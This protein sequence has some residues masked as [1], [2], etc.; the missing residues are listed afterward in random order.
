MVITR[1]WSCATSTGRALTL[2]TMAYLEVEEQERCAH[3]DHEEEIPAS[4]PRSRDS[5]LEELLVDVDVRRLEDEAPAGLGHDPGAVEH[6]IQSIIQHSHHDN[7]TDRWQ[8]L[9]S[10]GARRL[11]PSTSSQ[12]LRRLS[13]KAATIE[14]M[15]YPFQTSTTVDHR[16]RLRPPEVDSRSRRAQPEQVAQN[17]RWLVHERRPVRSQRH[18]HHRE[19]QDHLH[20]PLRTNSDRASPRSPRRVLSRWQRR[21]S[22]AD[23]PTQGIDEPGIRRHANVVVE[24]D[25]VRTLAGHRPSIG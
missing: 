20:E 8:R 11:A 14:V 19:E 17:A 18:C 25:P 4:R 16:R 2:L 5:R 1:T 23:R 24:T 6:L 13:S 3:D 10:G 22:K 9:S 21:H 15:T 12:H 7:H